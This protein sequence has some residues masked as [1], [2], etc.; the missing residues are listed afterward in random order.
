MPA[1]AKLTETHAQALT[2]NPALVA[3]LI[4]SWQHRIE[5]HLRSAQVCADLLRAGP[6]KG[7]NGPHVA[8][9]SERLAQLAKDAQEH[10]E[11][12]CMAQGELVIDEEHWAN[13][14]GEQVIKNL[15]SPYAGA[16][17]Q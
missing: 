7:A 2:S 3:H 10:R 11:E 13:L 8:G 4:Y 5:Y 9:E 12:A 1:P 14:I 15:P 17:Y 16:T 6:R